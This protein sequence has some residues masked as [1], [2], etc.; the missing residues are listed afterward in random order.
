[1]FT[2][3][4][5]GANGLNVQSQ[6]LNAVSSNIANANTPGYG[7]EVVTTG[8]MA[9]TPVRAANVT[10]ANQVLASPLNLVS[11]ATMA[12][13]VPEFNQGIV[14]SNI[15][16]N[17]AIDGNGFFA[18]SLPG[19]QLAYTRAGNF[20]LDANGELV[21]PTGARLYPPINIPVG[22]SYTIES[23]GAVMVSRP[24]GTPVKAG[25][26]QLALVPNPQGMLAIGNTL[27]T[28]SKASGA[29]SLVNPGT[30]NA[31]TLVSGALNQS[32]T[33]M[34][35]SLVNLVQAETLYGLNARVVSV[36]ETVAKATTNIQ[37]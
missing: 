24:G 8:S 30:T 37:V 27:F 29:A 6:V 9:S 26:I 10:L 5:I 2:V 25:Q 23:N 1:M 17:L 11:G 34:T 12:S 3:M 22:D 7:E 13:D 28:L 15:A 31:G 35:D 16:S 19:G 36:G 32:S 4:N 18:V 14:S 21:L 33:N 20:T